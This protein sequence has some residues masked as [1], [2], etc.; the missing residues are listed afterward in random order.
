LST[1][2]HRARFAAVLAVLHES[3][4]RTV[5]DLGCGDGEL[6]LALAAE[7]A[8]DR[9]VGIDI[10]ASALAELRRALAR[11]P[12]A[13]SG[14]VEL[15]QASYTAPDPRLAGFAAAVM[16]ETLE[17]VAPGRLAAVEHAVFRGLAPGLVVVTTPNADF[18]PLLGVPA[19]RFRHPD[20]R[21]EWGRA[22]FAAWVEGVA[23]RHGYGATIT[24]LG[25]RHPTLGGP[26]QMAVFRRPAR[27]A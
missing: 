1:T 20:H 25:G 13:V 14:K 22:R 3:A 12:A 23:S 24:D 26:S 4:A 2:L 17:H 5:L 16:V 8:I 6:L 9:V 27:P 11:C 19:H 10:D 15:R 7:P 18:N 21:F